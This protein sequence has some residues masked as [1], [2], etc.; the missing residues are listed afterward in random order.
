MK[1]LIGFLVVAGMVACNCL[2]QIPTQYLD[3]G[4]SCSVALPDY[5]DQITVKDN[6]EIKSV[7]Q[8]P[9][10]GTVLTPANPFV[11]VIIEATDV[12]DNKSSIQFT[13]IIDDSQPPVIIPDSSLLAQ[14]FESTSQIMTAYHNSLGRFMD[15]H[16]GMD[17]T[18]HKQQ[19]VTISGPGYNSSN[20]G[21]FYT[22]ANYIIGL[23]STHM[24]DYLGAHI[25]PNPIYIDAGGDNDRYYSGGSTWTNDSIGLMSPYKSERFGDFSYSIPIEDGSY[26]VQL[27]FAEIFWTNEG[28]R[29]FNVEIENNPILNNFDILSQV[30][31][32]VIYGFHH[33]VD[34]TDGILDIKF[35]TVEDNAKVSLILINKHFQPMA[36]N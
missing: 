22:T 16:G 3:V 19:L 15:Q 14:D 25:D 28:D 9:V 10:P 2:S 5:R 1:K 4:D 35:T 12:F 8:L 21:I 34:V 32:G 13:V 7:V 31:P 30:D 27:F 17:S 20:F 29:V 18:F 23:D 36:S 26:H 6:C 33:T 11:T 24:A